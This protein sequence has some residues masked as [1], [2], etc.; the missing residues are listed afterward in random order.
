[1]FCNKKLLQKKLCF[2]S[3]AYCKKKLTHFQRTL[4]YGASGVLVFHNVFIIVHILYHSRLHFNSRFHIVTAISDRDGGG[5][6]GPQ[7][8]PPRKRSIPY[9]GYQSFMV[10]IN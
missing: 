7:Q 3:I 4:L 6:G 10:G 1:M 2:A 5:G 9:G 8:F